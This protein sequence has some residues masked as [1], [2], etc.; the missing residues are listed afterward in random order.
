[1]FYR[2]LISVFYDAL[3]AYELIII[4][5]CLTFRYYRIIGI[6]AFDNHSQLKLSYTTLHSRCIDS[7]GSFRFLPR[8]LNHV[9]PCLTLALAVLEYHVGQFE[10]STSDRLSLSARRTTCCWQGRPGKGRAGWP[11]PSHFA[12]KFEIHGSHPLIL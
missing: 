10:F 8:S 11:R 12:T 7:E 9:V 1:M 3:R 5:R 4:F 6:E 2:Q